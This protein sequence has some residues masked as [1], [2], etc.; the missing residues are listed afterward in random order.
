M[1]DP[2]PLPDRRPVLDRALQEFLD[3][4]AGRSGTEPPDLSYLVADSAP[5]GGPGGGPLQGE[6]DPCGTTS[7]WLA[8]PC[9]PTGRVRVQVTRPVGAVEPS[10]VVLFL[11]G[12]GWSLGD[13]DC[14]ARLV[15]EFALGTDAAVVYVDYA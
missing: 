13:A 1:S 14:Y 12:L 3:A 10:P 4:R 15:R 6:D 2:T 9:G 8:L 5:S 7:E 11:P